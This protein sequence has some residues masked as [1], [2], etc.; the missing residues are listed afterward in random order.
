MATV[1]THERA[2]GHEAVERIAHEGELE[3]ARERLFAEERTHLL[4]RQV[5]VAD[6]RQLLERE[7]LVDEQADLLDVVFAHVFAQRLA[8]RVG[9]GLGDGGEDEALSLIHI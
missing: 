1:A 9:P 8:H 7:A 2:V 3:I 5:A 4:Q 6:R